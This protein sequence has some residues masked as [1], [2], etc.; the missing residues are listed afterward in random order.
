MVQIAPDGV[1]IRILGNTIEHDK[2]EN[3]RLFVYVDESELVRNEA[4][5]MSTNAV[6]DSL[7]ITI[8]KELVR[9]ET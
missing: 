9:E 8:S 3:G 6:I 2:D 4:Q 7:L 5:D 1:R